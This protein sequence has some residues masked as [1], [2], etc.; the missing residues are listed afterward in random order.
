[1]IEVL[2]KAHHCIITVWKVASASALSLHGASSLTC[3]LP[4]PHG[5]GSVVRDKARGEIQS[6]NEKPAGGER[7]DD[8]FRRSASA[9]IPCVGGQLEG[10]GQG[11][12]FEEGVLE[13]RPDS[14]LQ[15]YGR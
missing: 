2:N 11:E 6:V 4:S 14:Q 13:T 10:D 9:N 1:M 5:H 12:G 3:F 7:G 15:S 8:G